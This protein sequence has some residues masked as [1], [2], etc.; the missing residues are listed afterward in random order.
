[1][2]IVFTCTTSGMLASRIRI[3]SPYIMLMAI[4]LVYG[5]SKSFN[6]FLTTRQRS[7]PTDTIINH[8]IMANPIRRRLT[9]FDYD[10]NLEL[11]NQTVPDDSPENDFQN[12]ERLEEFL[13]EVRQMSEET[14]RNERILYAFAYGLIII[15]SFFGNL[16]VCRVCLRNMTKTNALIL[17]LAISDLTMV[18]V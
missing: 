7:L 5:Q 10:S 3:F 4:S 16:L 15:L 2:Y 6:A 11:S 9:S 1:M 12:H 8:S 14:Y 18:R 13:H 17:S